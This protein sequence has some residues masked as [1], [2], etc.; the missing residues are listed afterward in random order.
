MLLIEDVEPGAD[1]QEKRELQE[2]DDAG[3]EQRCCGLAQIARG[4]Q[5]L[6]HQL[7]GAVRGHGEEGAAEDAGPEGVGC[8]E[9]EREVEHVEFAR[10]GCDGMNHRP[11]ALHVRA[12][13]EQRDDGAAD[14][15]RHLHDVGPDDGSHAALER[16]E[17]REC[18]DDGDGQNVARADR[19]A[20]DDRDCED[21]HALRRGARDE[22]E[23]GGDLVQR[24]AEAAVDELVR[25]EHL[26]GEVARKEE[27]GDDDAAE[28][29]TDDDLQKAEV[30]GERDA[31]DGDDGESG[32]FGRDDGERDGPP[33]D[34]V[35]GEEVAFE[36]AV[37]GC[38]AARFAEAQAEERDADEVSRYE[39]EIEDAEPLGCEQELQ[40]RR[41]NRAS[42]LIPPAVR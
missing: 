10:G 23:R 31:G 38:G 27:G 14:V 37:C 16:I 19:D 2:D 13:R 21:A 4:E 34:R 29:V 17:Q 20:D 41:W 30:A 18:G 11:A 7:V 42:G 12:E 32:G 9:I 39:S 1:E 28:H 22:K 5:A 33:W 26:A 8:R 36:R 24:G 40:G 6:H 25:G 3:A 15:D 35:V